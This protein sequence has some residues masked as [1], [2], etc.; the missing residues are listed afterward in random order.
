[1]HEKSVKRNEN[2]G[3][4]SGQHE[5]GSGGSIVELFFFKC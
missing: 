2:S 3:L 1:M 5:K 4:I